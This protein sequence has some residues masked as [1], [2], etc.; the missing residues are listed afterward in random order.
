MSVLPRLRLDCAVNGCLSPRFGRKD[1]CQTHYRRWRTHGDP[2]GWGRLTPEEY[3]FARLEVDANGCWLISGYRNRGGYTYTG[4]VSTHRWS[5]E[6]FKGPIPAGL[7]IDHLCSVRHCANPEHLEAVTHAENTRRAFA[8]R[9]H[10]VNGHPFNEVNTY[11]R[12]DTGTRQCRRCT[13]E[14]TY[15]R[16]EQMKAAGIKRT[17]GRRKP[18]SVA[19]PALV[20]PGE[21]P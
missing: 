2:L 9:T 6:H 15:A 11:I 19:P 4:G 12:R 8:A 10:C 7:V 17:D 21:N 16:R 13:L 1:W 14:R 5:Y 20:L 18:V 3:F